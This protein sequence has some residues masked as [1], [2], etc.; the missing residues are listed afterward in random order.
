MSIHSVQFIT[1]VFHNTFQCRSPIQSNP[2]D[3]ICA[4]MA[5]KAN[6]NILFSRSK[7]FPSCGYQ[8]FSL[9][10]QSFVAEIFNIT[11]LTDWRAF[12]KVSAGK[13]SISAPKPGDLCKK[14]RRICFL[15]DKVYI[16]R[17]FWFGAVMS[18]LFRTL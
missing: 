8:I 14:R 4:R 2:S 18:Y 3:N 13:F 7:L 9:W 17:D 1:K 5:S 6:R 10:P 15:C 11:T 12:F 16:V